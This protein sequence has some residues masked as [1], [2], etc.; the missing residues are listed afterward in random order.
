MDDK[1]IK[2]NV[3]YNFEGEE[4]Q[5]VLNEGINAILRGDVALNQSTLAELDRRLQVVLDLPRAG[6]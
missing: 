4:H 2:K 3:P 6:G 1:S 5:K